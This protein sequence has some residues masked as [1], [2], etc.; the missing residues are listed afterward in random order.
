M[1]TT[2]KIER[3][4]CWVS[5]RCNI[6]FATI[7]TDRHRWGNSWPEANTMSIYANVDSLSIRNVACQH[8]VKYNTI[9]SRAKQIEYYFVCMYALI[10]SS[11]TFGALFHW[12]L[13]TNFKHE[14][15]FLFFV[16]WSHSSQI[17]WN[18]LEHF[19]K[20]IQNA[21]LAATFNFRAASL[22]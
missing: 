19:D 21:F 12:Y 16:T 5:N 22:I 18:Q 11:E 20:N 14:N 9:N 6:A 13:W 7:K 10:N 2:E 1:H 8:C 4:E 15:W 17:D 3:V